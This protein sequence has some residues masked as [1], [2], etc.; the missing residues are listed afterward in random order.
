MAYI[1][2]W[3]RRSINDARRPRKL[4]IVAPY[5]D[6]FTNRR[7]ENRSCLLAWVAAT[8]S[9]VGSC[10]NLI[11]HLPTTVLTSA[12]IRVVGSDSFTFLAWNCPPE[13]LTVLRASGN[14]STR[15]KNYENPDKGQRTSFTFIENF[16]AQSRREGRLLRASACSS[17]NAPPGGEVKHANHENISG[18]TDSEYCHLFALSLIASRVMTYVSEV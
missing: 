10:R 18:G 9:Q 15:R 13:N 11:S 4:A 3:L 6:A 7:Q 16:L 5:G 12:N 2:S 17:A 14:F 8:D 1:I